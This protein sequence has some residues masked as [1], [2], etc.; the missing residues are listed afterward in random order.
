M[1]INQVFRGLHQISIFSREFYEV[2]QTTEYLW[3]YNLSYATTTQEIVNYFEELVGPIEYFAMQLDKD[4]DLLCKAEII[5][6]RAEDARRALLLYDGTQF[7]GRPMVLKLLVDG[8]QIH[9]EQIVFPGSVIRLPVVS[10]ELLLPDDVTCDFSNDTNFDQSNCEGAVMF[11]P[12]EDRSDVASF[13]KSQGDRKLEKT[14]PPSDISG[15]NDY[16]LLVSNLQ[17]SV[18]G[19][20]LLEFFEKMAGPVEYVGMY[21]DDKGFLCGKAIIVFRHPE[22]AQKALV[23]CNGTVLKGRR[24]YL[25]LYVNGQRLHANQIV[26]PESSSAEDW[27]YPHVPFVSLPSPNCMTEYFPD[28]PILG[29]FTMPTIEESKDQRPIHPQGPGFPPFLPLVF[30]KDCVRPYVTPVF[31]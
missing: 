8:R 20:Q 1:K 24:I 29:P 18:K 27:I 4:T 31:E 10:E 6:H 26:L 19:E 14:Y 16:R 11:L 23:C 5:F 28:D 15:E 9:P 12:E 25:K 30:V 22:D 2:K 7:D 17:Y 21:L 3:V 13:E